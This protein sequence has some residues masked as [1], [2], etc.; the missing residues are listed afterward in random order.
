MKRGWERLGLRGRLALAIGAIVVVAFAV[1]FVAVRAQMSR[2]S[3]VI[4][5]EEARESGGRGGGEGD[6]GSSISPIKD[7]QSDVEKT[8]FLVGGASLAAALLAGYLVA[9][10]AASPLRR[11]AATAAEVDAGDLTPR[12]RVDP[13]AA[14]ELRT[15]AEAFNHMLDR[16]D[17][18][19]ARQR[20]FV[21]DASHELRSP[22]TAIRGQIEVLARSESPDA[23]EV[24]RVAATTMAEMARVERLVEDLLALARLDEGVEPSLAELDPESFLSELAAAAPD[25]AA[26]LGPLAA[27]TVCA[28]PD[29]IAQVVRNL[30]DNAHR[31]AGAGGRVE[32]SAR[33]EGDR[34]IVAVD[35]D[36]EGI[37]AAERERVFD[38]FHRSQRARDRASGG[39]GLGLGIARA[40]VERHGGRIWVEDSPLGGARVCFELP[41]Y[42]PK[43]RDLSPGA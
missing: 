24:R 19:F 3:G 21:S 7:A 18:A 20:R 30:L 29:L 22:L 11:F 5:R 33:G 9:A 16:L 15:L 36:G 17:L 13:A 10:R 32:L 43:M 2:E 23:A 8:F 25:R 39:S 14:A 1:V 27:G 37:E 35:D 26:E 28:D 31:H 38:R 42:A 4:G 12:L 6:D 34:L 41:G 40:I